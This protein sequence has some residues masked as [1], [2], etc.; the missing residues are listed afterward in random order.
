MPSFSQRSLANLSQAHPDLQVLFHRVIEVFDCAVICGYRGPEE[1]EAAFNAGTSKAHFG[2]SKHNQMPS[3]AVDVVPCPIDWKDTD[4]MHYF[5]GVVMG[6]A[7]QLGLRV[8]WG[9]DWNG[10]TILSDQKLHDL[11]HFELC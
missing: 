7:L 9:G 6:I 5:A 2:Q 11:P 1:Q 10:N 8:R 4:R 3:L